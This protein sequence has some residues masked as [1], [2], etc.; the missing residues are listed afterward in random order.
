[1]HHHSNITQRELLDVGEIVRAETTVAEKLAFFS[2]HSNNPEVRRMC[3]EHL[4]RHIDNYNTLINHVQRMTGG[5][6]GP[7]G[8]RHS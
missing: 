5:P 7:P 2:E 4:S 8:V 6:G 3:Q 1:M